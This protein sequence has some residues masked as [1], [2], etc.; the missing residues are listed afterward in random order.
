VIQAGVPEFPRGG[1]LIEDLT[2]G[3]ASGPVQLTFAQV[4]GI[5]VDRMGGIL[6]CDQRSSAV[7]YFG[8]AGDYVRSIGKQGSGPGEYQQPT[9]V[10][11]LRDG[12]IL[13]RDPQRQRVNV[14]SATGVF[15]AAWNIARSTNASAYSMH[16]DTADVVYLKSRVSW[17]EDRM[18]N[19]LPTAYIRLRSDGTILDTLP[20]PVGSYSAPVITDDKDTEH[21]PVPFGPQWYW[22]F[23]PHGHF[24]TGVSAPRGSSYS[25]ELRRPAAGSQVAARWGESDGV[26][27]VRAPFAPVRVSARESSDYRS[28][29]QSIFRVFSPGWQWPGIHAV[30]VTK[31]PYTRIWVD[32]D[33]RIWVFLSGVGVEDPRVDKDPTELWANERWIE[34]LRADL[35]DASGR[36]LGQVTGKAGI[37]PVAA[38]GDFVYTSELHAQGYPVVKRYRIAWAR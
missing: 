31:A 17:Q 6:V 29:Y 12:R 20:E 21:L 3:R 14:Y 2:I 23:S 38:R 8:A 24:V 35:F 26:V 22:A 1:Q 25:F 13:V 27:S 4:R 30:P 37:H 19:L 16:V 9:A 11:F 33:S 32:D 7:H 5:A 36:L 18:G 15:Q 28:N 10:A 34:P